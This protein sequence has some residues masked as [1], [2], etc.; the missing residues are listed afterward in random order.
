VVLSSYEHLNIAKANTLGGGRA[1]FYNM[2]MRLAIAAN[3]QLG[4][5]FSVSDPVAILRRCNLLQQ[6][7]SNCVL[8]PTGVLWFCL[9]FISKANTL[10]GGMT[11][12]CK[13]PFRFRLRFRVA[14]FFRVDCSDC[15]LKRI[16][17]K[18][19]TPPL[20]V[21]SDPW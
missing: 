9:S 12:F 8:P 21:L 6:S 1:Q 10:G 2:Q 11:P 5:I 16:Q 17:L 18:G 19:R 4:L 14:F 13:K 7:Y 15:R 20:T 3:I